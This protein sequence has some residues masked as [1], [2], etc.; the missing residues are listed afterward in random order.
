MS[1]YLNESEESPIC[2][3]YGLILHCIILRKDRYRAECPD[4]KTRLIIILSPGSQL[5]CKPLIMQ[6]SG[7]QIPIN[8]TST[9]TLN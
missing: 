1:R 6:V 4:V 7:I 3:K 5:S 2:E 8:F 9:I